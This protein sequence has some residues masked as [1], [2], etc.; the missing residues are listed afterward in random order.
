VPLNFNVG[1]TYYVPA[2]KGLGRVGE[3]WE[4]STIFTAL[5]GRPYTATV[6]RDR[7]GQNFDYVRADCA[8]GA[9]VQYNTRDPD[10]YVANPE[11]FSDPANGAVGTCGRNTLRGP[12]LAQ[13]DVALVKST[14]I[15]EKSQV[16]LRVEA[17]NILNRANF[18]GPA[19]SATNVRSSSFGTLSST[20][21]VF[22]LNPIISQGGPRAF[23]FALKFLF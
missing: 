9:T 7:S 13:W 6:Q 10:H 2:I 1:G 5:S 18:G 20:A 11:I 3:G 16:Q 17:F 12:G 23:Q 22:A 4:L 8:V 15:G 21:D 14:R 19:L